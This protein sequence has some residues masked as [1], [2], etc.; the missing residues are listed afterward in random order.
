VTITWPTEENANTYT[1]VIKN[2]DI[3][4]CTL[5]FNA[6][7][8]LLNIAFAPAKNGSNRTA[9]YATQTTNGLR[10]TVTGLNESTHYTYDITAKSNEGDTLQTHTGAFTTK[11][12]ASTEVDNINAQTSATQKL[13][14]DNQLLILR[15]GKT[16]NAMGQE[17]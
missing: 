9:Q 7:G 11:S 14:R 8:Q 4:F 3:V 13:F 12:N 6:N 17:M 15:A 2:G 1:I 5:T 16:Y 10:F